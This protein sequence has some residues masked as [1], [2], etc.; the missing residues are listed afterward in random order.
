MYAVVGYLIVVNLIAF[1]LM[2]S[3]K[4]KARRRE[5]RIP[6]RTLFLSAVIGGSAGAIVGMSFWRHKTKHASFRFG[7]PAILVVQLELAYW[8]WK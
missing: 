3:D 1:Y 4:Q 5:R 2:G 7:M 8:Y 6:E